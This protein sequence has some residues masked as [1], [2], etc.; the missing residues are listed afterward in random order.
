MLALNHRVKVFVYRYSEQELQY[1]MLKHFPAHDNFWGPVCGP[2]QPWENPEKA[3]LREVREETG[4]LEPKSLLDLKSP[5]RLHLGETDWIEWVY[6]YQVR[7]EED[8]EIKLAPS[9]EGFRWNLFDEAYQSME[10]EENRKA[11]LKLHMLL[12]SS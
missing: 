2:I 3:V 6:G 8:R 12:A 4:F 5:D 1:L 7:S 10:V 9:L 11:M